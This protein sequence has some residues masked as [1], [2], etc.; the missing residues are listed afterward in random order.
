MF[1]FLIKGNEG[2]SLKLYKNNFK[3]VLDSIFNKN[4]FEFNSKII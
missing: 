3:E 4:K 2:V 1:F